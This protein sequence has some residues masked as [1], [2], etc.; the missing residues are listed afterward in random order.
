MSG[1]MRAGDRLGHGA[2]RAIRLALQSEAVFEDF[3]LERPALVTAGQDRARPRQPVIDRHAQDRAWFLRCRASIG[4]GGP[5]A[6]IG[7]GDPLRSAPA[8]PVGPVALGPGLPGA[9]DA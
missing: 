5:K 9:G 3:D 7:I 2:E 4:G 6:P 8:G 1:A